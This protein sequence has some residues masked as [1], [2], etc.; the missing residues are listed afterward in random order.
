VRTIV[1]SHELLPKGLELESLSVKTGRVS[2][3]VGS[4]ATICVCPVCGH[5]SSRVHSLYHRTASDL[6][7]HGISVALEVLAPGASSAT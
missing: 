3:R 4:G 6:P 1:A 2:I 5:T 7:W